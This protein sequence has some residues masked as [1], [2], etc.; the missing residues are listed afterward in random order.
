MA[1]NDN[2]RYNQSSFDDMLATLKAD[3]EEMDA[4]AGQIRTIVRDNL[5]EQGITGTTAENLV[6]T[7]DEE[8]IQKMTGY[9][10][11]AE[12]NIKKDERFKELADE[13]SAKNNRIASMV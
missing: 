13:N 1:T 10:D 3:K 6:K 12:A 5:L 2:Y 8:V 11:T 7:F 4:L 9:F